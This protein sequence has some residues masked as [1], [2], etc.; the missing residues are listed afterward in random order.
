MDA[1]ADIQRHEAA[2][3]TVVLL[4]INL[5]FCGWFAVRDTLKPDAASTI[6]ALQARGIHV[7]V[8][9]G[10]NHRTA[11]AIIGPLGAALPLA[12]IVQLCAVAW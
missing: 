8:I 7:S 5:K 3:E 10:D 12:L 2:G 1:E 9:T 11:A 6:K 4:A